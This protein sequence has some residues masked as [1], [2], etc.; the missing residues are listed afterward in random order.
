MLQ[1]G[2]VGL[3][4]GHNFVG[5][6]QSLTEQQVVQRRKLAH[7]KR[8]A[9][10]QRHVVALLVADAH[11]QRQGDTER[12]GR[13]YMQLLVRKRIERLVTKGA[14]AHV[15]HKQHKI[16]ALYRPGQCANDLARGLHEGKRREAP[17]AQRI[18]EG[19]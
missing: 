6:Q 13:P 14:S 11:R 1:V 9:F 4:R 18:H 3:T 19:W 8:M 2:P 12:K 7:R 16:V 5:M 15:A 17:C 10:G